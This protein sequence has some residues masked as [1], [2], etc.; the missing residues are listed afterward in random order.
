MAYTTIEQSKRLIEIGLDPE[1]ADATNHDTPAWT[2]DRLIELLPK[3]LYNVSPRSHY[4]KLHLFWGE[5]RGVKTW[6]VEYYREMWRDEL[7]VEAD[8][9]TLMEA[10]INMHEAIV[11]GRYT[12]DEQEA[13]RRHYDEPD[14]YGHYRGEEK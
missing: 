4:Y 7:L 5:W 12:S 10:V 13:F 3:E 8:G 2:L 14:Q 11:K 1:T 9:P 6:V